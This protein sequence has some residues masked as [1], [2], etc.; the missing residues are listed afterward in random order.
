MKPS[1]THTTA[2]RK[3]EFRFRF[4]KKETPGVPAKIFWT[5]KSGDGLELSMNCFTQKLR[6]KNWRKFNKE[7][8]KEDRK[9]VT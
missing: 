8:Q 4:Q 2:G 5:E 6:V 9:V 7:K 1:L 3:H